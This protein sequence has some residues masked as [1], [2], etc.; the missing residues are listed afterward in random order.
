MYTSKT[1]YFSIGGEDF[2]MERPNLQGPSCWYLYH[3]LGGGGHRQYVDLLASGASKKE[4]VA[5]AKA[6]ATKVGQ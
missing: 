4:L 3:C 6:K 1:T 5:I 2:R